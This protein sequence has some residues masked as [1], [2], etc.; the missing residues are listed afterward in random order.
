MS[1]KNEARKKCLQI[2]TRASC[3]IYETKRTECVEKRREYRYIKKFK[4][5]E[6]ANNKMKQEFFFKEAQYFNTQQLVLPIFFKDKSGNILSEHGDIL[7][8]WRQY[9]CDLQTMNAI[10][11]ELISE[12]N[13]LK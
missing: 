13:Q 5:R 1:Q 7:Q 10:P 8:R 9:F 4:E 6:Q 2:K 12:N 11:E 3:E